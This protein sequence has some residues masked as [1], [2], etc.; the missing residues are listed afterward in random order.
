MTQRKFFAGDEWLYFKIYCGVQTSNLLLTELI[1]PL[2]QELKKKKLIHY[3]FFVRY[4]DPD[5]HIRFRLMLMKR[6]NVGVVISIFNKYFR[7]SLDSSQVWRIQT[8]TYVRELERYGKSIII[9]V[10][11]I[12]CFDSELILD[13]LNS[14]IN[15]RDLL[16]YVLLSVDSFLKTFNLNINERA[17]FYRSNFLA[18]RERLEIKFGK[19][20]VKANNFQDKPVIITNKN[21]LSIKDIQHSK[22]QNYIEKRNEKITS[23]VKNIILLGQRS[24]SDFNLIELLQ[25]ILH[26]FFNKAFDNQQII[27]EFLGYSKL[28]NQSNT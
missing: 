11:A 27:Y 3:W 22:I 12:F 25:S 21:S 1:T 10:E 17:E 20:G 2:V 13:L 5:P 8:D 9:H 28:L 7:P 6:D 19:I 15:S 16:Q 24:N 14:N 18:N 23:S 4:K 26:M